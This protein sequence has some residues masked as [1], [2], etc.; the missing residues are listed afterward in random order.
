MLGVDEDRRAA[1][2]LRLGNDVQRDGGLA[3][4]FRP[5]DLHHAPARES[6]DAQRRSPR[7]MEPLG[8][9][10]TATMVRDPM[11]QD[12]TLAELLVHLDQGLVDGAL[13]LPLVQHGRSLLRLS[14]G[15]PAG[16]F[17][18]EFAVD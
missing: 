16:R 14:G 5:K 1:R 17:S 7:E 4:R 10:S 2:L 15:R 8:I 12:G 18:G 11:P 9:T 3:G 6:A 13:A